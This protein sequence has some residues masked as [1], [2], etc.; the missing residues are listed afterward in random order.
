MANYEVIGMSFENETLLAYASINKAH[1]DP[2]TTTYM[3]MIS[4]LMIETTKYTTMIC[5]AEMRPSDIPAII[6]VENG[7]KCI[8]TA[9]LREIIARINRREFT[10]KLPVFQINADGIKSATTKPKTDYTAIQKIYDKL[11]DKIINA[12]SKIL[13]DRIFEE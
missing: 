9:D 3:D 5:I 2:V 8:K 12:E 4:K 6:V 1:N 7:P 10:D 13:V 11:C